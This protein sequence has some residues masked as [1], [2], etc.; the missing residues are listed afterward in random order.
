MLGAGGLVAV[1]SYARAV[2]AQRGDVETYARPPMPS[3]EPG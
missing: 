2:G 3:A 1:P